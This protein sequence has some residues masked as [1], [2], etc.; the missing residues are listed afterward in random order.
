MKV[1]SFLAKY[2]VEVTEF[3]G[4]E[5][6]D[7][8]LKQADI[9]LIIPPI[10]PK[11]FSTHVTVGRGQHFEFEESECPTFVLISQDTDTLNVVDYHDIVI[12]EIQRDWKTQFAVYNYELD[13]IIPLV[14]RLAGTSHEFTL[15]PIPM[16]Y[17]T[18]TGNVQGSKPMLALSRKH[19]H[20]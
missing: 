17:T 3:A 12:E 16:F 5:Y 9:V 20:K 4:G 8:V 7:T 13:N 6:D 11:S 19:N 18:A 10:L 14:D 15:L 2:D 1:R